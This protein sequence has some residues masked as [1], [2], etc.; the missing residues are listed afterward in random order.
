MKIKILILVLIFFI[1]GCSSNNN[2][3]DIPVSK[4]NIVIAVNSEPET[5]DPIYGWGNFEK[6]IIHSKLLTIDEFGNIEYDIVLSHNVSDN[7][8]EVYLDLKSDVKFSD[9]EFLNAYDVEFTFEHALKVEKNTFLKNLD[10]C[11]VVSDFK[12][13]FNL[14]KPQT[15]FLHALSQIAIVPAHYY[16]SSYGDKPIGSGPYKL[17]QWTKGQQA[18]FVYN[19]YYYGEQPEITK[20]TVLFL[21][22][23]LAFNKLISDQLDVAYVPFDLS[24]ENINQMNLVSVRTNNNIGVYFPVNPSSDV[25]TK[26]NYK[27][28][29]DVTSDVNIRKAMSYGIDRNSMLIYTL[30]KNGRI[31]Y[32][33]SDYMPWANE[34][35]AVPFDVQY[36]RSL[37]DESGWILNSET[38]IREKNGL[39]A[40]F[41][42]FYYA[43]DS[44]LHNLALDIAAQAK[45]NLGIL[46]NTEGTDSDVLEAKAFSN[47]ILRSY[48]DNSPLM[49]YFTYHTDNI[50]ISDYNPQRYSNEI[51]DGY[52][53]DIS[54]TDDY[55]TIQ[56]LLKKIQYYEDVEG[57]PGGV[58]SKGDAPIVWYLNKNHLYYVRE[59][60]N[61]KDQET[62]SSNN[63]WA[64]LSNLNEWVWEVN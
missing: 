59:G 10:N 35:V 1:V 31:A 64:L 54:E 7:G 27:I 41:S 16:D 39:Q 60:L 18:I 28:G 36:A 38:G 11:E 26:E 43:F 6:S 44:V 9:G 15:D 25:T 33:N 46:I 48:G 37:L 49:N 19:N 47:A 22:E 58:S 12:I 23:E 17:L 52:I 29:N 8:L 61:I 21:D 51:I 24:N 42:L 62:H 57:N 32:S 63:S 30:N 50:N 13:K 45:T 4:D 14:K 56:N 34:N 20:I 40:S 53:N 2:V 3:S 55:N 5:F